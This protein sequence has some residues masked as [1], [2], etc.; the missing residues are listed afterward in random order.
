MDVLTDVLEA[1]RLKS[2]SYG[3]LELTA[4][5]GLRFDRAEPHFYV[6]SRG[7]CW[8]HVDVE[9]ADSPIQL[10]GG[11]FVLL[12]KGS[13][14]T[15][16]DALGTP[17]VSV[18]QA[19]GSCDRNHAPRTGAVVRYGGGGA[20]TTLVG[21]YFSTPNGAQNLLFASLPPVLHVKGDAGTTVRWLEAN[22]Q[23]VASEMA[24][25][26]PGFETIVSRLA[27]I[28]VV[29]AVRAH[30]AQ[31]GG[32]C[33]GWLRAL[34]DPQ[35]GQALSLIHEKPEADWTV[36]SLA[37]KVGMSRSAFAARFAQLVEEPPLTYLTRWRMQKASRLLETTPAG[38]AEI[39]KRVG[40][41]AEAAFSKAFKRWIG[42]AP[43]AYR[44]SCH[45]EPFTLPV[46]PSP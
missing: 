12:P 38:V 16:K 35:I 43:G 10:D 13:P 25:G 7:T 8:L 34:V 40:Y 33:K 20:A 32:G 44:R 15:L 37:S 42:V 45:P 30:L 1:A 29:Q 11:D 18:E 3:R 26:E 28:L 41:D 19:L 27:D 39:A 23:F 9:G 31:N 14:H 36:E 4:P 2:G 21:G 17:A 5:W 6:V 22:L 24:S 46:L